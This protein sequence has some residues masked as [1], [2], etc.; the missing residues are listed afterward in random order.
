M[1]RI[2]AKKMTHQLQQILCSLYS[3]DHLLEIIQKISQLP[4]KG[5]KSLIKIKYPFKEV[6]AITPRIIPL[7]KWEPQSTPWLRLHKFADIYDKLE[8]QPYIQEII[9]KQFVD[10]ELKYQAEENHNSIIEE[11]KDVFDFEEGVH[12]RE[13]AKKTI[14][15]WYD[16]VRWSIRHEKELKKRRQL[17]RE[18]DKRYIERSTPELRKTGYVCFIYSSYYCKIPIP[19]TKSVRN[20]MSFYG[21]I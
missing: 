13:L 12:D 5:K 7:K 18:W 17:Y 1:P 15:D 8:E 19:M 6:P 21:M 4:S 9:R 20:R 2:A 14:F 11:L 3:R 16:V 10:S